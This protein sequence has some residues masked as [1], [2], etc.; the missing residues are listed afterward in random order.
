MTNTVYHDDNLNVLQGLDDQTVDLIYVKPP[1]GK[2]ENIE[3]YLAVLE[4]RMAQA[5][6]CLKPSGALYYHG[7]SET[8]HYCKAKLLDPIFGSRDCFVNEIIWAHEPPDPENRWTPAHDTILV[9]AKT[10]DEFVFNLDAID[11]IRYLA[12]GLV[13]K[14]KEKRGK[15]PTDTWWYTNLE[16]FSG[17]ETG[18]GSLPI[19]IIKRIV[20]ASSNPGD[21]VLDFY[22][23]D[24]KVGQACLELGRDFILVDKSRAALEA[25]AK[26]FDGLSSI[27]WISADPSN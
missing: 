16:N 21:L 12:P 8:I 23:R 11:R 14:E 4:P 6:R 3:V 18:G 20:T 24:G 27:E 9:Y 2:L 5:Y 10:P 19:Q 13:G 25:M 15:L 1:K 22:A 7:S 17:E 26:R